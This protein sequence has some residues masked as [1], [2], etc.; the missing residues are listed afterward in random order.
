MGSTIKMA[1][2]LGTNDYMAPEIKDAKYT[3]KADVFSLGL[4]LY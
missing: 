2:V 3:K 4:T 1:S